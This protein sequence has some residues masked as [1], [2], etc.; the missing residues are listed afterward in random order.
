MS[1]RRTAAFS[2]VGLLGM[3]PVGQSHFR[4]AMDATIGSQIA[5]RIVTDAD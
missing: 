5:P 3:V 1:A 4:E 2:R